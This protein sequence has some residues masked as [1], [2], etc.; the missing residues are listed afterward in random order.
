MNQKTVGQNVKK[1]RADLGLTQHQT[2]EKAGISY[3]HLSHVETGN[4]VMSI[5]CLLNL[6]SALS[7]TPN[8]ILLGEY[9]LKGAAANTMLLEIMEDLTSDENRFLL[10]MASSM[11]KLRMNR[12]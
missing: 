11:R 9:D 7:T 1:I 2:A 6:C 12:K 5:D 10:E 8:D 4:T 3:N